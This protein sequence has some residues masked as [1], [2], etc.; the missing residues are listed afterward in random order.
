MSRVFKH[1]KDSSGTDTTVNAAQVRFV[2]PATA[3]T[4][5]LY[6]GDGAAVE[7]REP[8][9]AVNAWLLGVE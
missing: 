4:T 3:E 5:T 8:F 2:Q 7:V 6:F 9:E 1:F